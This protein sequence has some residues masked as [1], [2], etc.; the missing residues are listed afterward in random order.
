MKTI[1]SIISFFTI[2]SF[3]LT[4]SSFVACGGGKQQSVSK[5]KVQSGSGMG[6]KRDKN[7]HVWGK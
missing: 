1:K 2:V 5:S 3:L 6:N 4:I 7:K